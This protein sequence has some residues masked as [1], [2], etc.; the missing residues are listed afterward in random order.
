MR[1]KVLMAEYEALDAK[2]DSQRAGEIDIRCDAV[3]FYACTMGV[4]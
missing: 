3:V 2:A 1:F 4:M